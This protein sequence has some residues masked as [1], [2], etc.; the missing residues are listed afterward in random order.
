MYPHDEEPELKSSSFDISRFYNP[1]EGEGV[2]LELDKVSRHS[3]SI[4][5]KDNVSGGSGIILDVNSWLPGAAEKYNISKDIR[6][7]VLVPSPGLITEMPNTNGD[8][9]TMAEMLDFKQ[10]FGMPM[11]KTFKCMPTFYEHQG[12]LDY[13]KAKGI[14]LDSFLKPLK[15]FQGNHAKLVLL[16]AYDRTR[17]SQAVNSILNKK[18]STHSVGFFYTSYTCTVCGHTT[19]QKTMHMCKHTKLGQ[20][21]YNF[22]GKLA[23]R[24]CHDAKGFECSLVEDPAFVVNQHNTDHIMDPRMLR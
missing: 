16:L 3:K 19:H 9:L 13:T 10:K 7:Y 14:I 12:N 17:D 22:G 5:L 8:S 4:P 6:D 1:M 23:F 2:A 21:P 15:G 11:Y 18:I 20:R 24:H